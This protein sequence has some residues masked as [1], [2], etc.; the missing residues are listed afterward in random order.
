MWRRWPAIRSG[1]R[2]SSGRSEFRNTLVGTVRQGALRIDEA[3]RVTRE[4][5]QWMRG[6]KYSLSS[7]QV[8][9]LAARSTCSAYDCEFVALAQDLGV[10]LVSAD[11]EVVAAFPDT[12][13]ALV[14][15]AG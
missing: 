5:E 3:L 15:F 7:D 12:A 2:R 9:Q 14:R 11:R 8:L 6:R 13:V 10:A 4:A 1:P